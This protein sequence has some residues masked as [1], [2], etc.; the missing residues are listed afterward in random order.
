MQS[1]G[2]AE[3]SDWVQQVVEWAP[4][5]ANLPGS[6][7]SINLTLNRRRLAE[8]LQHFRSDSDVRDF[9]LLD[10]LGVAIGAEIS[11][12]GEVEVVPDLSLRPFRLWEYIWLYKILGLGAGGNSVLDLGGPASHIVISA[13]LAGN[14]VHSLDLNPRIV[15]AGRRCADA[16][17]LESY[18]AEVGDMR[19]LSSIAPNSVDRIVCCSVLEHLTGPDQ[20]KALSE[21]ARVLAPGGVIG[22]TFDYGAG[23]PGVNSY[24]PPPHEPPETADQ[25]RNRYVHSGLEILGDVRLEDPVAGSL[26]RTADVSYTIAALF[27]GKPPLQQLPAPV[28]VHRERSF[29]PY[30]RTP[31]LL[32]R[33]QEKA[34]S[35]QSRLEKAFQ[36]VA[37]DRLMALEN[38]HAELGR[39][40]PELNLREQKLVEEKAH[41]QELE[42]SCSATVAA[43]EQTVAGLHQT[44]QD[45]LGA[46]ETAQ[47]ELHRLRAELS[48][49][50]EA[51]QAMQAQLTAL[52][53][54]HVLAY[55]RRRWK[56]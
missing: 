6:L 30:P 21:M 4:E 33:L 2:A 12:T 1:E 14:K 50:Q 3:L 19:D 26:F 37:E 55:V 17:Q 53:N 10:L 54:E 23:A 42:R 51:L 27:L 49:K 34:R 47:T 43:L 32:G 48:Q 22:L 39:L 16:F 56:R 8:F 28:A 44:A 9:L 11:S 31:D 15:Q 45:R 41:A 25:V 35:D 29:V 46:L 18:R 40:Y 7:D 24:L 5:D 20:K 52:Q 38:A 13:A 36:Q